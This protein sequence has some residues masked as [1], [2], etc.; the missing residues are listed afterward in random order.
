MAFC[1]MLEKLILKLADGFLPLPGP[2]EPETCALSQRVSSASAQS[3]MGPVLWF[4]AVSAG[5]AGGRSCAVPALNALAGLV[6][7][8]EHKG[9]RPAGCLAYQSDLRSASE[10]FFS[11]LDPFLPAGSLSPDRQR[12]R[13][14]KTAVCS[15]VTVGGCGKLAMK[16]IN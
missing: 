5:R 3:A 4:G 2:T 9:P 6:S 13:C 12:A 14:G 7:H 11:P 10:G 1:K 15:S 16:G 8:R